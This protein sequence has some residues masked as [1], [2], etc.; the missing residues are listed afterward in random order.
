LFIFLFFLLKKEWLMKSPMMRIVGH[1]VWLLTALAGIHLGL[2]AMGYNLM[3]SS[4][5]Q[6]NMNWIV[7]PLY[8]LF[9]IAGV[10]SLI[11][12]FIACSKGHNCSCGCCA[13]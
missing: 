3:E 4:F 5:V 1:A 10:A 7:M 6:M 8:Y 13:E 12:F 9:G 2:K 11:M